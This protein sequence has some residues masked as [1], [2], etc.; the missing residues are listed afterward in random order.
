MFMKHIFQVDSENVQ[1]RTALCSIM[2]ENEFSL[3][4]SAGQVDFGY[5]VI[6]VEFVCKIAVKNKSQN[7]LA[8]VNQ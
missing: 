6:C 1:F 5:T 2:K 4:F 3:Q 8:I 7:F